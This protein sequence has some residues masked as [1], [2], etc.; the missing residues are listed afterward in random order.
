[1]QYQLLRP[2]RGMRLRSYGQVLR[3][4]AL[5]I[6]VILVVYALG[7]ASQIFAAPSM[8]DYFLE[9]RAQAHAGEGVDMSNPIAY[10]AINFSMALVLLMSS[11]RY[12]ARN[13]HGSQGRITFFTLFL[14]GSVAS[15]LEGNRSTVIVTL[16]SLMCFAYTNRLVTTKF[17]AISFT[18]FVLFFVLSMQVLRLEGDFSLKGLQ[19][20]FSWFNVYAF[21]SLASFADFFD[22]DIL[23]FWYTFDIAALKFGDE[24]VKAVGAREFFIIDYVDIGDLS[25][26]V[27]SGY[28]VLYDYLGAWAAL[29]L[30]VKSG[31]FY[32]VKWASQRGFIG[33]ACYIALLSSYPLTIYHEFMLTTMYYCLNIL[34][35]ALLLWLLVYAVRLAGNRYV[36]PSSAASAQKLE[37]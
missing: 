35:L 30:V 21:G 32:Y 22:H 26:N 34:V 6:S 2:V 33:N 17:M 25:T 5:V 10:R 37:R 1:M 29:Y 20:A 4:C 23:T 16:I 11:W 13:E 24:F 8:A 36:A 19:L 3:W 9:K 31:V 7:V 18:V 14:V 28:A 15:L 27:Y 12:F